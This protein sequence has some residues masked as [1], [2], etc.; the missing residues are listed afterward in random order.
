MVKYWQ[1]LEHDGTWQA[2]VQTV[3]S[4]AEQGAAESAAEAAGPA[5]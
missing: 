2:M 4:R 5:P 3:Q 1:Q